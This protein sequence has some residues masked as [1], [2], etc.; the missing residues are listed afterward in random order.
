MAGSAVPALT[1]HRVAEPG[2]GAE[3][4]HARGQ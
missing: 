1:S 4:N 3:E 2:G